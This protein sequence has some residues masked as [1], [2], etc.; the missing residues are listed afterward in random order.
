MRA[1]I[2]AACSVAVATL[3]LTGCTAVPG[4]SD[5]SAVV[6]SP[7]VTGAPPVQGAPPAIDE[8]I[9]AVSASEPGKEASEI[10]E[11]CNIGDQIPLARVTGMGKVRAASDLARYVP[12]TGRE[13]QLRES[14][15]AWVVTVGA[16]I[17]QPGSTEVWSD[18]T[19]VVTDSEAGYFAT[20]P[21]TDLATGE[22]MLPEKPARQ[23]ELRVPP[24]KP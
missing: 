11:K 9:P 12:L 4:A 2:R 3:A 16:D 17:P 21:V 22:V 1:L 19:C 15:A 5:Q 8:S 20:G 13:P 24:L 18:P 6:A 10:L 7:T 23:P 14:G